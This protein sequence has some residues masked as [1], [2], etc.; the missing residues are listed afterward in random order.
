VFANLV[1]RYGPVVRAGP[2]RVIF[3]NIDT[4]KTIYSTH[5]FRKSSWYGALTF[6]GAHN[7]LSTAWVVHFLFP[8]VTHTSISET[9]P[10]MRAVVVSVLPLFEAKTCVQMVTCFWMRWKN[11]LVVFGATV[12][13][14][15]TSM[16]FNCSLN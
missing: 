13:T 12:P 14:M 7:M 2:N 3:R 9:L 1:K 6:G 11:S 15:V 4:L 10:I 16:L 8:S 5:S